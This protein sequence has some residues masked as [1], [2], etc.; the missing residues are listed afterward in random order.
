M[1]TKLHSRQFCQAFQISQHTLALRH[2]TPARTGNNDT[3]IAR[4]FLPL[5]SLSYRH[6]TLPLTKPP[7]FI[8]AIQIHSQVSR[9]IPS[10]TSTETHSKHRTPAAETRP[11]PAEKDHGKAVVEKDTATLEA[12]R[13]VEGRKGHHHATSHDKHQRWIPEAGHIQKIQH[14]LL[15]EVVKV[16]PGSCWK[17]T[18][19]EV[20]PKKTCLIGHSSHSQAQ[21][22]DRARC[23]FSVQRNTVPAVNDPP[24][25]E[26]TVT[27]ENGRNLCFLDNMMRIPLYFSLS[28]NKSR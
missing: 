25:D 3:P 2:L 18:G 23:L 21:T 27:K 11:A 7:L 12:L 10:T 16:R 22:E 1:H 9:G 4:L 15:P 13:Q 24:R 20:V 14:L 28:R 8:D 5:V 17:W 26:A 19:M 6:P